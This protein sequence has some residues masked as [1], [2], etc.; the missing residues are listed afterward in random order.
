MNTVNTLFP[1]QL[2]YRL[3]RAKIRH[4]LSLSKSYPS[5]RFSSSFNVYSST[6]LSKMENNSEKNTFQGKR[7]HFS[8][9]TV[10]SEKE[11]CEDI[12]ELTKKLEDSLHLWRE[13]GN[14][15][16]WFRVH[17]D[18]SDW[19]PVLAKKGFKFH[20]AKDEHVM[21]YLWLPPTENCNIP[22]YAHTMVGVGAVVVNDKGQI[23][24]VRDKHS[25]ITGPFWKLPGGYVE[26]GENLVDAAIRE[27]HEETGIFTEFL[28]V[29][30]LRHGHWGMF[31]CSDIYIVVSLKPMSEKIEM[32]ERE[33]AEC[34][35]MD[36][37]E[38]LNH[39]HVSE[40]NRFF[41]QKYSEYDE[42]NIKI[43][44]FHG[45]HPIVDKVYTM[46]SVIKKEDETSEDSRDES[47]DAS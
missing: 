33:I 13:N 4:L 26:P 12:N 8:G 14:R 35:W 28:S 18:Q 41:L 16:I 19:V 47:D 40:H 31:K 5:Y 37:E 22:H 29:L 38:Y 25:R 39:P 11:K 20:H 30:T 45:V 10:H 23:L 9:V 15:G 42:H 24:A 43:N 34:K 27:V 3:C 32:C 21:M 6:A 7:D 17:L 44:C 36:I 1:L 46:Y 2:G